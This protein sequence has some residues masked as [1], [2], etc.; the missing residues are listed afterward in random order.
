[1]QIIVLSDNKMREEL[2][3]H[4]DLVWVSSAEE[5]RSYESADAFIDLL[6]DNTPERRAL[7]KQLLPKPILVNSMIDTLDK[8]SAPFI[9]INGWPGFIGT[10]I[11]AAAAPEL[12]TDAESIIR[13]IGRVVEWVPDQAGFITPRVI[14]MIINEAYF[15][16]EE[17][18]STKKEID[19]AMKLGTNYPYG[20][21]EWAE[22]IGL[23]SVYELLLHLS[24]DQPRYKPADLLR[25]SL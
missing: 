1:M 6:Y 8:I 3:E 17:E 25:Q 18:I 23:R 7:L 20:P 9:R 22:K 11:E 24:E 2:G 14:S 16:L 21:F 19:T 4:E 12:R 10:R 5:F 13:S 15:A